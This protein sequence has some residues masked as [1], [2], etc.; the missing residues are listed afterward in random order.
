MRLLFILCQRRDLHH[1]V[2][3]LGDWQGDGNI[4]RYGYTNKMQDGFILMQWNTPITQDFQQKQLKDDPGIIDFLVYDA[5][6]HSTPTT[7]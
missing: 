2:D 5:L 7:A 1:L 6:Q 4:L 3:A